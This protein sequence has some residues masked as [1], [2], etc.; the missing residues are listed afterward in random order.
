M[1]EEEEGSARSLLSFQSGGDAPDIPRTG[2]GPAAQGRCRSVTRKAQ[3]SFGISG[4]MSFGSLRRASFVKDADPDVRVLVQAK[5]EY[6]S[7]H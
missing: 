6:S 5:T 3:P 1:D 2:F 4:L 7:L